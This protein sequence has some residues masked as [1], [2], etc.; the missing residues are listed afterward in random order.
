MLKGALIIRRGRESMREI[1]FRAWDK[2]TKII[3]EVT[4]L[5]T[6]YTDGSIEIWYINRDGEEMLCKPQ[7]ADI[8]LMQYTGL[9]DK[10]GTEI[11]EGDIV[12]F[13]EELSVVRYDEETAR[14]VLDDY[15]I[16]GCLMEYGWDEGAGG[17]GVVNTNGFDDFNDISEIEVIG[18]IHENPEFSEGRE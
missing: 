5:R 13:D 15:G 10:N 7:K 6:G 11:Y 17:I 2:V 8:E 14:F 18:N 4:G 12:R 1:R 9:N 16:F 3:A